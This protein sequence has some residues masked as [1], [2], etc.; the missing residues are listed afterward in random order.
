MWLAKNSFAV[1]RFKSVILM[2]RL[3]L[4]GKIAD[5]STGDVAAD[6]YHKYMVKNMGPCKI[7]STF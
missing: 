3:A 4:A 6:G 5:K 7:F 2:I 1:V